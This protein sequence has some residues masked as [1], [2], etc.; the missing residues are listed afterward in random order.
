MRAVVREDGDAREQSIGLKV[1]ARMVRIDGKKPKTLAAF[2]V[3]SPVVVFHPG[4]VA[5]SMGGG[6]E[7]R[8]LLDRVAL[9]ASP[10]YLEELDSYDRAQRERMKAL[11]TR[12]IH[13]RDLD[14]WEELVARHGHAVAVARA[15]AEARLGEAARR[16]FN[17]IA[18]PGLVLET[19][20]VRGAPAAEADFRAKLE[21]RRAVDLRRGGATSGPHRDDMGLAIDG[22]SVRGVASQGQHRAVVLSLKLA[23]IEVIAETRGVRPVLLLDD[24]SSELDRSRTAALFAFLRD[25]HGQVLLTTTRPELIDLGA[26]AAP[27]ERSDFVVEAGAFRKA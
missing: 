16:A 13:A 19:S 21:D 11:E 20:Y 18:A 24:V 23:E 5:L 3:A 9:Y 6:A 1:G 15:E 8:R 12:G 7:R 27:E 22:R 2:A 14:Q 17:R 25:H 10:A 4:V 26:V